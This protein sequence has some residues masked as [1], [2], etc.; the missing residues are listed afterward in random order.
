MVEW[1]II[2]YVGYCGDGVLFIMGDVVYV[3][4]VLGGEI[5]EVDYVVG[6][7]FDCCKLFVV[8]IVSFDCVMLFCLY[9]GVCGG[10]VI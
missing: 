6:Y 1:L 9:F 5:V 7:Y 8:E 2:D 4:Y 10:C 3:F